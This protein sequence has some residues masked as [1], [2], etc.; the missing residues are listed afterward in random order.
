MADERTP[1]TREE[2]D[3]LLESALDEIGDDAA[4]AV[5][6]QYR[7]EPQQVKCARFGDDSVY[8]T[9][10]VAA[11]AEERLGYDDFEKEF[12]TGVLDSQQVL[13]QWGTWGSLRNALL[14]FP[15]DE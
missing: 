6:E 4:A 13:R 5:W 15:E 7:I 1:L 8:A 10:V 2:L 9:W 12:G 14:H 11:A 3:A